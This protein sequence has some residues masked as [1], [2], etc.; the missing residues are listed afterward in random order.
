[1]AAPPALKAEAD[2]AVVVF[3]RPSGF[4]AALAQTILD[5]KG[6]FLGDA[7]PS[8]RFA[9][10][11]PS[12]E[13]TF[14]VWAENTGVLKANLAPG[15][16]YFVEV[17]LSM[18]FGSASAELLAIKPSTENWAELDEWLADTDVFEPDEPRGQA[19]LASRQEDV[20]D[21]IKSARE[22]LAGFDAEDLA[23]HSLGP[24]DGR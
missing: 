22:K 24:A 14:I 20:D 19:Y 18:G 11:V 3:M 1:M 13:H 5:D 7:L 23:V 15:K 8:S 16:I 17:S 2:K 10:K 4:G 9:V 21:R 6:R 12:G